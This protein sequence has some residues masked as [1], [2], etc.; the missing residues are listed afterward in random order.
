MRMIAT[1]TMAL[2]FAGAMAV[3]APSPTLAQGIYFQGPGIEFGVGRPAYRERYYRYYDEPYRYSG[4]SYYYSDHPR[5][6]ERRYYRLGWD[7]D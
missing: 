1:T 7:W 3:A 5:R 6:H 2:G 4:R